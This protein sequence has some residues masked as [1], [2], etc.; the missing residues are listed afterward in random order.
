MPRVPSDTCAGMRPAPSLQ[1][2]GPGN[3]SSSDSEWCK[4]V[5]PNMLNVKCAAAKGCAMQLAKVRAACP[6]WCML[7]IV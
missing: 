2:T 6:G 3:G 5:C 4:Q 7:P 1:V